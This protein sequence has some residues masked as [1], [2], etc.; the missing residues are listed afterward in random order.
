MFA[1][2]K[3][4]AYKD[5]M[6]E[7]EVQRWARVLDKFKRVS[8]GYQSPLSLRQD[9]CE[10]DTVLYQECRVHRALEHIHTD[11]QRELPQDASR[12]RTLQAVQEQASAYY[13]LLFAS[14]T[15]AEKLLLVQVAQ[16]GF[17]NPGAGIALQELRRKN[18]VFLRPDP[19]LMNESFRQFLRGVESRQLVEEWEKEGDEGN[20][21]LIR[22]VTLIVAIPVFVMVATTQQ[23]VLQNMVTAISAAGVLLTTL[24]KLG[25]AL[26]RKKLAD[27]V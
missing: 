8:Q 5:A 7:P 14:C 13:R 21:L 1:Q 24:F 19:Q 6:P 9:A 25:Q 2:E 17:L 26:F 4:D 3:R 11:L 12:A 22:N 20:W 10:R 15:R 23:Q 16:T 27:G 18:L